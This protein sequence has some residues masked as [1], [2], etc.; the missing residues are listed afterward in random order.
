MNGKA[1]RT[2]SP[3]RISI[4]IVGIEGRVVPQILQ[5]LL[6]QAH[7]RAAEPGTGEFLYSALRHLLDNFAHRAFLAC[8]EDLQ[9][10][11]GLL[12]DVDHLCSS[13][14]V[15]PCYSKSRQYCT[16]SL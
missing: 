6:L 4:D 16:Y 1:T 15:S 14:G 8:G 13:H 2:T 10:L 5:S 12:A 11:M 7:P 3:L 9:Q